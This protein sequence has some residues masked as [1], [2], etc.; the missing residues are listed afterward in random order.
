MLAPIDV[1]A[2]AEPGAPPTTTRL[3]FGPLYINP[4]LA[5]TNAGVDNNVFNEPDSTGPK[6]DFTMTVTPAADMWLRLGPSWLRGNVKEDLVYFQTYSS[7]NSA[8]TSFSLNWVLPFNRLTLNPGLAYLNTN[9]RPGFEIDARAPRVET[10]YNGTLELRLASKTFLGARI[11]SRTTDYAPGEEFNGTNLRQELNRTVTTAG[12]TLRY[13]ATP[14]TS[15][16]FEATREEARFEF[17]PLRDTDSTLLSG[18]LKFDPAALLKG[19]ATVGYRDFRPLSSL[20]PGYQGTI[21]AV[22]LSYV[23][24]STTLLSGTY[25]R[26]VQYS[27]DVNQPYYLQGGATASINQ[28]IFGPVDVVARIGAQ[29]LEYRVRTDA[30]VDPNRVDHVTTYGGGVGYHMGSDLRIGFNVDQYR[31]RSDIESNEYTGLRYGFSVTY[32]Q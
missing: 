19:S 27:Y 29:R 18:G 13:Q 12:L 4:L 10:D 15:L 17:S 26:D 14:L 11:D 2:Q 8:N 3:Q 6:R 25:V 9:D 21:A 7:Q 16:M 30:P 23:P 1:F 20:V 31:R 28:Q 22:N 5:L 32:G 24:I